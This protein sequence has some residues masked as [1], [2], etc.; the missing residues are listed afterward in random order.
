MAYSG[1]DLSALVQ[2]IEGTIGINAYANA[3]ADS[4]ATMLGAGYF[5]DGLK[6]GLALGDVVYLYVAGVPIPAYVSAMSGNAATVALGGTGYNATAFQQTIAIPVQLLDLA[7]G[8]FGI[9]V[10]F[11]FKV[12][13]AKFVTLKPATTAAKAATLTVEIA[14]VAVT[15]GVIALTSANQNTIGGS[16]AASAI[17]ALNTGAAGA[18]LGVTV[19]AV[20][21]FIEGDGWIEFNVTNVDLAH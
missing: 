13:S 15:G 5:S 21:A 19:S 6:R 20:T 11:A 17:T 14:T 8:T 3:A 9:T 16:V 2:T 10:P 1:N 7:A 18:S 12:N 4:L